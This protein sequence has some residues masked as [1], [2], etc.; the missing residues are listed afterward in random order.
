[1]SKRKLLEC[2]LCGKEHE[3]CSVCNDRHGWKYMAD[4]REHYQI[5]MVKKNYEDGVFS[6]EEAIAAFAEYGVVAENNLS[7]IL[8]EVEKDIRQIIGGKPV[9]A[10]NAKKPKTE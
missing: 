9:K 7:W 1:M 10:T 8:P 4:T 5:L 3:Y 2:W 6:K